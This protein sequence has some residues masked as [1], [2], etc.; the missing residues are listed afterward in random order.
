MS[1]P[2]PE[3][4]VDAIDGV[5]ILWMDAPPPFLLTLTF[6]VGQADES[7]ATA[8]ITHL[9]EHLAFPHDHRD[10]VANN[11]RTGLLATQFY[12]WG[13]PQEAA[14]LLHRV[15]RGLHRP[16]TSRLEQQ[17]SIIATEEARWVITARGELLIARYGARGPG[18]AGFPGYG[19][20]QVADEAV[21]AWASR[22]F[23]RGNAIAW[24]T[25]PPPP[26]LAFDLPEGPGVPAPTAAVRPGGFP[27]YTSQPQPHV[28][29]GL[30]GPEDQPLGMA[31][32][33]VARRLFGRLRDRDAVS[34]DVQS[35]SELVDARHAHHLI[36]ADCLADVAP[37]VT[38]QLVA[39]T[40]EFAEEG[41][42][43]EELA[44]EVDQIDRA[45]R[46]DPRALVGWMNYAAECS[47]NGID[48]A[49]PVEDLERRRSRTRADLRDA[50]AAAVPSMALCVPL[51]VEVNDPRFQSLET[52]PPENGRV[53]HEPGLARFR[54][55]GRAVLSDESV[56]VV[57]R[58]G[59]HRTVRLADVEVL[60]HGGRDSRF[61]VATDG[62]ELRL[63]AGWFSGGTELIAHIDAVVPVDRQVRHPA[64]G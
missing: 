15:T 19:V 3:I 64:S 18:V 62:T 27:R 17:R 5:P 24:M 43:P 26:R 51:S 21:R 23:T 38:D 22:Y 49:E 41:P 52:E 33:I 45:L 59:V 37:F 53:F 61:L 20:R 8:G 48:V 25:G 36:V 57:D 14:E 39:T 63:D 60:V 30:A 7:L 4:H 1:A 16:D 42:T 44:R 58:H 6:R 35:L 11:G 32:R 56:S 9:V 34:Y 29:V 10:G 47:L 46:D 54:K 28:A 13:D 2:L 31:A 55:G 40:H 12:S 50:W